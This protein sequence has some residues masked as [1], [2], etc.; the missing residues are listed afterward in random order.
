M[1]N[2]L[3]PDDKTFCVMSLKIVEFIRYELVIIIIM[4]LCNLP[5]TA[6]M[7]KF[8]EW[9]Y[10]DEPDDFI[11]GFMSSRYKDIGFSFHLCL[12]SVL[13]KIV[14]FTYSI[15]EILRNFVTFSLINLQ[16][17]EWICMIYVINT[18]KNRSIEEITF[19]TNN[20]PLNS[21]IHGGQVTY[22]RR[23]K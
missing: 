3:N 9:Y 16:I 13:G 21:S 11:N 14:Y 4:N 15:A 8:G 22:Q 20:E 2:P 23:E 12:P 17:F 18:Q 5:R 10:S 19:D 6:S 1:F 7:G